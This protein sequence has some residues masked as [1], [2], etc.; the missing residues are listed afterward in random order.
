MPLEFR[1][2]KG[3]LVW[4][5]NPFTGVVTYFTHVHKKRSGF[6]RRAQDALLNAAAEERSV[7]EERLRHELEEAKRSCPFCPGNEALSPEEVLRVEPSGILPHT[8][9]AP[10]GW[11][12]R[13]VCNL[14]PRI[15]EC[16]TGGRNESYVVIED[17]RHFADNARGHDDLL[18]SSLLAPEHFRA[19]L[20]VDVEV[21]RRSYA[22]PGVH[23]VLIRKNQGRE[24]GASQPHVHNQV[25]GSDI[26]FP[27]V[28]RECQVTAAEPGLWR[29]MA[30]F[31]RAN[32]FL[33]EERDGC[34]SYFC[35]YGT[36]PRSYEI[37]CLD[38]WVRCVDLPATRW[39]IFAKMLHNVLTILGPMPLDY[40]I[41]DGPGIPL[42][43]H[44]NARHFTYS[45]IGGTLN[46]PSIVL[47]A[48]QGGTPWAGTDS[49]QK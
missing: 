15:P 40:E 31:A 44:V 37:V 27:V 21:A 10:D 28:E 48:P 2:D 18:Y 35:T 34:V 43:A 9:A 7:Y 38:D 23:H 12:I 5:R 24:S 49:K 8:T 22:N 4:V 42:H 45:N 13:A 6:V 19:L 39:D 46:L 30:A 16:C 33:I 32:N 47:N 3:D 20:A 25:I 36:F 1:K 14:I 29:E 41:H 11:L 17:P 26:A